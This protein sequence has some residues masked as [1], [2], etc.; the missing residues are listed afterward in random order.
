MKIHFEVTIDDLIELRQA[1]FFNSARWQLIH[2]TASVLLFYFLQTVVFLAVIAF[3]ANPLF[4]VIPVFLVLAWVLGAP[5]I[6][7]WIYAR[8]IRKSMH[9]RGGRFALGHCEME[10]RDWSLVVTTELMQIAFDFRLIESVHDLAKY[11]VVR[12]N[13]GQC[14]VIPK[15]RFSEQVFRLFVEELREYWEIRQS[16]PP[17]VLR[18]LR[19]P[20]VDVRVQKLA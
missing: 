11:S 4:N 15:E 18:A 20:R 3:N 12:V 14:I 8:R 6:V 17:T 7:G 10:L 5:K 2:I 9:G 13:S 19:V 1:E 16:G